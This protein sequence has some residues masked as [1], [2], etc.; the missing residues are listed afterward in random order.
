MAA[1]AGS[2]LS[3]AVA[4]VAAVAGAA[5][6][7][8]AVAAVAGAAVVTG[9][10]AVVA[11]DVADATINVT[12]AVGA[13]GSILI[14]FGRPVTVPGNKGTAVAGCVV[15]TTDTLLLSGHCCFGSVVVDTI[16]VACFAVTWIRVDC[17]GIDRTVVVV[18]MIDCFMIF[19]AAISCGIVMRLLAAGWEG[20]CVITLL[21][22]LGIMGVFSFLVKFKSKSMSWVPISWTTI[23][24][25]EVA[26]DWLLRAGAFILL[27]DWLFEALCGGTLFAVVIVVSLGP[28]ISSRVHFLKK[29]YK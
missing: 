22:M 26:V 25:F 3:T 17:V 5:V 9:V 18:C 13:G 10:S 28:G 6:A 8:A 7:G 12:T 14:L 23:E 1:V 2:A 21:T 11:A 20:A 4:D 24:G 29:A 16:V 27:T 19:C 15:A